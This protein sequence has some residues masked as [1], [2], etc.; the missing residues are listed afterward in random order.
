MHLHDH[1]VKICK[2]NLYVYYMVIVNWSI[3]VTVGEIILT[4][5]STI[6]TE[7]CRSLVLSGA[8]SIVV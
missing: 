1:E 8:R 2:Q 4:E 7:L 6:Q 3:L 5:L